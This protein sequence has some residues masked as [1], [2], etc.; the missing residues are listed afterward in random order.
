MAQQPAILEFLLGREL[1]RA[2]ERDQR[3]RLDAVLLGVLDARLATFGDVAQHVALAG[4]F[5]VDDLERRFVELD[6]L[7]AGV[8]LQLDR[9]RLERDVLE[10][11]PDRGRRRLVAVEAD[12]RHRRLGRGGGGRRLR[13]CSGAE[14][15]QRDASECVGQVRHVLLLR[16]GGREGGCT[17]ARRRS[18]IAV[19]NLLVQTVRVLRAGEVQ[20][21]KR[22]RESRDSMTS[23][24]IKMPQ[25]NMRFDLG[26]TQSLRR[27]LYAHERI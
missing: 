22:T 14:R 5:D 23:A 12:L 1:D 11:A 20:R 21:G 13:S 26:Q 17:I 27:V 9:L 10:I 15:R 8:E 18:S 25:C 19:E 4:L 6:D 24:P 3:R 16:C 2:L 7:G